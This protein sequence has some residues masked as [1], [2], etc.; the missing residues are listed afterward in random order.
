MD[1]EVFR[2]LIKLNGQGGTRPTLQ[3]SNTPPNDVCG[4]RKVD[5]E[6]R[7]NFQIEV[8]R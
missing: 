4:I 1:K 2:I 8:L 6:M 7:L 3:I 5:Y